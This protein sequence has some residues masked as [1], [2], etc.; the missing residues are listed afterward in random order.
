ML[1]VLKKFTFHFNTQM[2]Y[3]NMKELFGAYTK[4]T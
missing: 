3:K 4:K 2:I 1:E